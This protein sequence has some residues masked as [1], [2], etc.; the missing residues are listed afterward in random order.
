ML[1]RSLRKFFDKHNFLLHRFSFF[2][3][4]FG[5]ECQNGYI[6]L[7]LFGIGNPSPIACSLLL[8]L[9][10]MRWKSKQFHFG[11]GKNWL[12]YFAYYDKRTH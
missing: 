1:S 5:I 12:G 10:G 3:K 9:V 8:Y 11:F 4:E 6:F 7:V 2:G